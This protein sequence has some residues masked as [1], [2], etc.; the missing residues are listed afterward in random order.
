MTN[1][2]AESFYRVEAIK[3]AALNGAAFFKIICVSGFSSVC[4]LFVPLSNKQLRAFYPVFWVFYF[5]QLP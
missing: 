5:L 1:V 2:R 3:K 4:R